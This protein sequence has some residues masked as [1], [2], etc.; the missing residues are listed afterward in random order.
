MKYLQAFR[1]CAVVFL[2]AGLFVWNADAAP[3]FQ[4]DVLPILEVN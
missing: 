2:T 3:D 1:R 4:R